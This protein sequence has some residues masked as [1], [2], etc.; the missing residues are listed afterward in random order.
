MKE[1]AHADASVLF[2]VFLDKQKRLVDQFLI[3]P[4]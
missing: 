1:A 4:I 2:V 3:I